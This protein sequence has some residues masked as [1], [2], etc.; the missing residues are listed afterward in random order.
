MKLISNTRRGQ[1]MVEAMVA[2]VVGVVGI[3]GI[4]SLLTNSLVKST[5]VGENFA[6]TYLA[7]EGVEVVRSLVDENYTNGQMD[8]W[9]T[10]FADGVNIYEMQYDV[11]M[12]DFLATF[13]VSTYEF[14][15]RISKNPSVITPLK[16]TA[17]GIYGYAGTPTPFSRIITLEYDKATTPFRIKITSRVTWVSRG[18]TLNVSMEDFAYDWRN[19][20]QYP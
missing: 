13:G 5:Q 19:Y 18:Q 2:S 20:T 7:A 16:K 11:S 4:V 8:P 3:L 15:N 6:A 14:M 17:G 12:S 10:I 9:D 1:M